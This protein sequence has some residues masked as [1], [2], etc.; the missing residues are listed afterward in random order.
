MLST[1]PRLS[2]LL[3]AV[4]PQGVYCKPGGALAT[5]Y[6]D[7]GGFPRSFCVPVAGA[8]PSSWPC[9]GPMCDYLQLFGKSANV[10]VYSLALATMYNSVLGLCVSTI[11]LF[12]DSTSLL[13]VL[14]N[15]TR[16]HSQT[17]TG[18]CGPAPKRED[19]SL[20]KVHRHPPA[21]PGS[22]NATCDCLPWCNSHTHAVTEQVLA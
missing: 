17:S 21:I 7:Y 14:Y 1:V 3:P 16:A 20:Q 15:S 22:S 2:M 9:T 12:R 13:G 6:T 18:A 10:E 8:P 4:P 19:R 11:L 5:F